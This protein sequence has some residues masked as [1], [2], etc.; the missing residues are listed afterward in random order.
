MFSLTSAER[1]HC[2]LKFDLNVPHVLHMGN[3]RDKWHIY[4]PHVLHVRQVT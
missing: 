3:V 1:L 4:I 2:H